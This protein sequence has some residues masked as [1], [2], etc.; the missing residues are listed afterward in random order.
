V[1]SRLGHRLPAVVVALVL[2]YSVFLGAPPPALAQPGISVSIAR[3][4]SSIDE[5]ALDRERRQTMA[6][7]VEAEHVS[8]E[9]RLRLFY[10]FDGGSFT[11]E[12]DW[13]Y[14]E[15]AAGATL[16]LPFGSDDQ[17]RHAVYLAANGVFRDNGSSWSAVNYRG[18]RL[19]ANVEL[20]PRDTATYRIGYRLDRR[21]FPSLPE[22]DQLHHDGFVSV[23]VNLRSRTTLVGEAHVGAKSYAATI[24]TDWAAVDAG[25][26]NVSQGGRGRGAGPALRGTWTGSRGLTTA[27]PNNAGMVEIFG[28]VAQSLGDRT[29]A[30]AQYSQRATFGRVPPVVVTTPALFFDDGVYDDPFASDS[31]VVTAAI[32]HAFASGV[33]V[34]A[35]VA[36]MIKDYTAA[37]AIGLDGAA[38]VGEPLRADRIWR[39]SAGVSIPVLPRRTGP[40]ALSL[41]ISYAFTRHRSNDAF[42]NYTSHSVASGASFSY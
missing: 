5:A 8:N 29:G 21:V 36:R 38:L 12:G 11:T 37:L 23:L 22:L 9:G 41:D 34:D 15:H 42:Y 30:W 24:D 17:P 25:A 27:T 6:G 19:M 16:R 32:R 40:T 18:L 39:A 13:R 20:R 28:R 26:A 10:E 2:A 31:R 1:N 33:N 7:S 35:D 3:T 4:M 14:F